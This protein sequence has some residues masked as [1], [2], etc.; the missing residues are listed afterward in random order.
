MLPKAERFLSHFQSHP[1]ARF[2]TFSALI[3]STLVAE[4]ASPMSIVTKTGDGG[5]TGLMYNRRVSK[6]HPRVEAVGAVDELSAAIGLARAN[7][8][9]AS[10]R[11]L[12]ESIQQD[13][14]IL[15]GEL[16]TEPVDLERYVRDGF[17][18]V[19][20]AMTAI[21]DQHANEL[22]SGKARRDGWA[23]PGSAQVTAALDF[24]RTSCRR[25][26][27]R[28]CVL[29]EEKALPNGEIVIYLNR[30]S[31]VLWLLARAVEESQ[32]APKK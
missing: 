6:C 23:I 29:Q 20:P 21:L 26:E 8:K 9:E 32:A 19:A 28:I 30:L 17:K 18:V 12:L 25:A 4:W 15:M 27:R 1:G 14:I 31:D 11:N 24:A 5:T 10:L 2:D 7:A 16:S 3:F 22:E 13:L